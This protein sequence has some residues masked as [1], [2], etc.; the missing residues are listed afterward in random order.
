[1]IA[2]SIA[3]LALIN[4]FTG[5]PIQL[6]SES[7]RTTAM[8]TC[9]SIL[10]GTIAAS[11]VDSTRFHEQPPLH[12]LITVHHQRGIALCHLRSSVLSLMAASPICVYLVLGMAATRW[13]FS[14]VLAGVLAPTVSMVTGQDA[15]SLVLGQLKARPA[16]AGDAAPRGLLADVTTAVILIHAAQTLFQAVNARVLIVTQE[17]SLLAAALIAPHDVDTGVLAATIV[18]Q[19]LVHIKTIMTI[20]SQLEAIKTCAAIIAWN[21][22]TVMDT[23]S[24]EFIF[25][26]I[27]VL[28]LPALPLV[29]R[30]AGALVGGEC[31]LT[32]GIGV[33]VI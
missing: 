10:T 14:S 17:K 23:A 9:R 20:M 31:I 15:V 19:A 7:N 32:D 4:V 18:L 21:I 29:P 12:P 8:N 25:T 11:I 6:E 22:Q 3:G 33:A 5:L 27:N 24:V 30:L 2:T 1:M 28:T 26:L 16:L 13:A